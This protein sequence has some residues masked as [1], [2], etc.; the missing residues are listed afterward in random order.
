MNSAIST[1]KIG[2][3]LFTYLGVD[4]LATPMLF[5]ILLFQPL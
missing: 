5:I 1:P 3:V 2:D 4:W